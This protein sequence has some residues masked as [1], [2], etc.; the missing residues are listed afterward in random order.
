MPTE[1]A[2]LEHE[3][4]AEA[5]LH[6]DA[7]H[8]Q[9]GSPPTSIWPREHA[10]ARAFTDDVD[11]DQ[12]RAVAGLHRGRYRADATLERRAV[13]GH[14]GRDLTDLDARELC[15]G[16]FGAPFDAVLP[17]HAQHFRTGLRDLADATV[18]VTAAVGR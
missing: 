15:L 10:G 8:R 9:Q 2:L 6:H 13:H 1:L 4:V 11:V 7:G 12:A 17:Q 14:D 18:E 5:I 3:H 16:D